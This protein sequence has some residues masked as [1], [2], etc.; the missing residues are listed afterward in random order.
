VVAIGV[1]TS[2]FVFYAEENFLF[3][4][5]EDAKIVYLALEL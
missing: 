4:L 5:L 3:V 2:G 1:G